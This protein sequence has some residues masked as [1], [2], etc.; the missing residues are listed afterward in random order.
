M[1]AKLVAGKRLP[2]QMFAHRR[3]SALEAVALANCGV[4]SDSA[5]DLHM[6]NVLVGDMSASLDFYRRL[7]SSCPPARPRP[8]RMCS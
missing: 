5:P 7:G 2:D 6:L 8:R 3:Q 4:M 1:R